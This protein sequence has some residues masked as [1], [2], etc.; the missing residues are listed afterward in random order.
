IGSSGE[1]NVWIFDFFV[2]LN[3]SFWSSTQEN[4]DGMTIKVRNVDIPSPKIIAI[5]IGCQN[6]VFGLSVTKENDCQSI[7]TPIV[8]GTNPRIVAAA[9]KKMG[10]SLIFPD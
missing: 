6:A 3:L 9:V 1:P 5:P 8:R 7:S 10:L 4:I 2:R